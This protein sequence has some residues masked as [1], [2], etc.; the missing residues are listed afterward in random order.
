MKFLAALATLAITVAI[1][2]ADAQAAERTAK[3][4]DPALTGQAGIAP[5]GAREKVS[6]PASVGRTGLSTLEIDRI[7][8][9]IRGHLHAATAR[10]AERLFDT[11]TPVIKDYYGN[12]NAFLSILTKQLEPLANA[13]NFS[14]TSIEREA[15][16]AVQS[17]ILTGPKGHEWLAT[18]KLQRQSDGVWA[19]RGCQVEAFQGRQT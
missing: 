1:G 19:I 15:N 9:S 18:F 16:D 3:L 5:G 6:L 8:S 2:T 13:K 7:R 17:V 14:F 4:D 12:S 11:L 10:D